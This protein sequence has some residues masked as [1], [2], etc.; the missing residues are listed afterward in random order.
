MT[1]DERMVRDYMAKNMA[2]EQILD[3]SISVII[4]NIMSGR[5]PFD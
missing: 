4:M 2:K 5:S 3:C 1:S